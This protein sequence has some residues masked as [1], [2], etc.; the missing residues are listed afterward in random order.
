MEFEIKNNNVLVYQKQQSSSEFFKSFESNY[1]QF[2]TK[3]IILSI[4]ESQ[5]IEKDFINT[6]LKY[7]KS[8]QNNKQSFVVVA[9]WSQNDISEEIVCVP[10]LQEAFDLIEIDE[11]QRDLGF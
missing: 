11:M 1:T 9:P 8:H 4:D 2:Q 5:I 6:I 7:T 10:T 3:N